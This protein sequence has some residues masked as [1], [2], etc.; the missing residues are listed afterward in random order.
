LNIWI[1]NPF[2]ELPGDTDMRHR[3]WSLADTLADM[4]HAVTWW[5]SDWSHRAKARRVDHALPLPFQLRKIHT[6]SYHRNVSFA[7]LRNHRAYA[8]GI[9]AAAHGGIRSGSLPR[10]D[11]IVCSL[12][13][14]GSPLVAL[15]LRAAYGGE[16]ILDFM[17]AWPETF[18]RVLP[19]P[20]W[21]KATMGRILL[22]PLHRA[23][24]RAITGADRI[25]GLTNLPR[26]RPLNCAHKA[27]TPLLPRHRSQLSIEIQIEIE[28]G[29]AIEI[30]SRSSG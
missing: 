20:A 17:D 29:I 14:L 19:G 7:R 23:A 3:Y 6:P 28:I 5:S 15:E 9:L 18:S 27:T 26:S 11:R 1:F 2:D 30:E 8:K 13:P 12:P 21:A 22:A 4:G 24:R 10:P 16:V 25:S